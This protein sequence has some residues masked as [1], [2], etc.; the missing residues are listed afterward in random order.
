MEVILYL[1]RSNY[2]LFKHNRFIYIRITSLCM[3]VCI[4]AHEDE[5][6]STTLSHPRKSLPGAGRTAVQPRSLGQSIQLIYS[7]AGNASSLVAIFP[8]LS[9]HHLHKIVWF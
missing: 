2:N 5:T 1:F 6:A 8:S 3:Y 4:W 7:R 9:G